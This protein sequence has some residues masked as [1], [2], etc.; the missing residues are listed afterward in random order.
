MFAKKMYK[1]SCEGAPT[2]GHSLQQIA[3]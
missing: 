3:H 1:I 2:R